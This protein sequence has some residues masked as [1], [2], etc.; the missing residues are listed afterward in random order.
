LFSTSYHRQCF[1]SVVVLCLALLVHAQALAESA[2]ATQDLQIQTTLGKLLGDEQAAGYAKIIEPDEPLS[3][4]VY[5]PQ[6][7][8]QELPGVL[9]Y[10]SPTMSGAIDPRWREA[11]D[12]QNMIYVA[13]NDSGNRL[14]VIKRMVKAVMAVKALGQQ[15][16]FDTSKV[17]VAGFSGGG[18]VASQVATQYPDGFSGALYICGVNP[19]EAKHTPNIERALQ[20]RFVFLTGSLDFNRAETRKVHKRYTDAGAE[21]ARLIVIKGMA[22]VLPGAGALNEAL[23]YLKGDE[24]QLR[25]DG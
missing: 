19:W 17:F 3:W 12:T 5:V 7:D 15:F 20:N 1:R 13:A 25:L 9:V 18:R 10:I 6:G 24:S 23:S 21:H 14:R 22:H 2:S 8:K 16:A 4:E 11:L